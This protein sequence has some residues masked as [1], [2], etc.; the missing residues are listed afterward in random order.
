M[1]REDKEERKAAVMQLETITESIL[2]TRTADLGPFLI[3]L[4]CSI[5]CGAAIAKVHSYKNRTTAN[6]LVT[7]VILPAMV[8]AVIMMVNG[9]IGAGVAVAGAFSLVRFRSMP[10]NSREITAVFAAMAVGL[11]DGMRCPGIAFI[12]TACFGIVTVFAAPYAARNEKRQLLLK[13]LRITIPED[14]DY[15]GVFDDIFR[16]YLDAAELVRVKTTNMGSLYELQYEIAE[17]N[18]ADE[19]EMLDAIRTR[20]GNLTI[21][22]GRRGTPEMAL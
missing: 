16:R 22:C 12:L 20:N 9:N 10:G 2:E 15:T 14:L 11:A 21:V 8:Q 3:C 17:K 5:L 6:F 19:K 1:P 4:A 7:L 13:D 18:A